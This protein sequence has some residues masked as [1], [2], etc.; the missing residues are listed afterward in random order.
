MTPR[1]ILYVGPQGSETTSRHRAEALR[2]LGH[3]VLIVDPGLVLPR[4]RILHQINFRTGFRFYTRSILQLIQ[5][6][7]GEFHFDIAWVNNGYAISSECVRWLKTRAHFVLS[8]ANDDPTGPRDPSRWISFRQA[9]PEYDLCVIVRE[10]NS[11]EFLELGAKKVIRVMMSYD[12]MAHAPLPYSAEDEKKWSSEVVFVGTWM[13]ERGPFMAELIRRGVPLTIYGDRW[14]KAREWPMIKAHWRP[15]S[16][17]GENYVKAVQYSNVA[18]GMLSKGNRDMHTQRSSEIPFIGTA[19]CAERTPE[20]QQMFQEGE[21]ALFWSDAQE[22]AAA[23]H[24]LLANDSR[25][26]RM[27]ELARA[28]LQSLALGN[29]AICAR[30]IDDITTI[31]KSDL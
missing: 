4:N 28:K 9:I 17:F 16:A 13:P 30:I 20:H 11:Q 1:K 22:C 15:D 10:L 3:E 14:N 12:E 26:Q 29:E 21:E 5:E 24:F 31:M 23:C 25:R 19:F 8:Y 18:V 7:I 6:R 27:I 2:R